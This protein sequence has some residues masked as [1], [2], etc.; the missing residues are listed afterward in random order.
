MFWND[1]QY[2]VADPYLKWP[3]SANFSA[4]RWALKFTMIG[5]GQEDEI[6]ITLRPEIWWHDAGYHEVDHCM[7]WPHPANVRIFW[8]RPAVGAVVLNVLFN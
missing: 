6:E 7:K 4:L 5:L 3:Y 8:S 1:T 2:H